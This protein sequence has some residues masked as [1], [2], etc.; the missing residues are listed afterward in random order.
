MAEEVLDSTLPV[1][2]RKSDVLKTVFDCDINEF[3]AER[4]LVPDARVRNERNTF[5]STERFRVQI[6]DKHESRYIVSVD[7]IQVRHGQ[8]VPSE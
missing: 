5:K 8:R 6:S 3:R 1:I 4:D 7:F 2:Y